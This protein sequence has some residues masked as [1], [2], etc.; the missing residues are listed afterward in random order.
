MS[1][2]LQAET[3]G[4]RAEWLALAF[5]RLKGYRLVAQRFRCPQGEID[6]IVHRGRTLVFVE[7]KRRAALDTAAASIGLR[8]QARI[9]AAAGAFLQRNPGQAK[10]D[11]RFDAVLIAPGRWPAH[12][13]DAFRS[14]ETR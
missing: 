9:V 11:T 3:A 2:R 7:V 8:Q 4:R 10:P 13:V 5:L 14:D 6:L 12:V 1:D